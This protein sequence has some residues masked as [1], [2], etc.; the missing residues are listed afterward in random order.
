MATQTADNQLAL[1]G[2]W[3]LNVTA[4]IDDQLVLKLL[5]H[6][7]PYIRYW[8]IRLVGDHKSASPNV[9]EE[10]ASLAAN[11]PSP[12]V[13]GQLAATAKRLPAAEC[14]RI[15]DSLLRN[16]PQQSDPR[17]PWLIWWAFESKSMTDTNL[18]V[19]WCSQ[20]SMWKNP[21]ARQVIL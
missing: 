21:A 3:A 2:L 1:E 17:V 4:E 15:A 20:P 12:N 11:E 10:L 19:D 7:Y 14:L 13:R 18:L 6:P 16:Q 9:I 5:K 8:T